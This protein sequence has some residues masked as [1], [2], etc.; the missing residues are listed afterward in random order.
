MF[1]VPVWNEN[2]AIA[3]FKKG[4]KN[5]VRFGTFNLITQEPLNTKINKIRKIEIKRERIHMTS[6]KSSKV[7]NY[8]LV[9][10]SKYYDLVEQ[11]HRIVCFECIPEIQKLFNVGEEDFDSKIAKYNI[12]ILSPYILIDEIGLDK[13][14]PGDMEGRPM[15]SLGKVD[16]DH[17]HLRGIDQLALSQCHDP[18]S[19]S[20]DG[21]RSLKKGMKY[22][23]KIQKQSKKRKKKMKHAHIEIV[24]RQQQSEETALKDLLSDSGYKA[25]PDGPLEVELVSDTVDRIALFWQFLSEYAKSLVSL[26]C[27]STMKI[28]TWPLIPVIVCEEDNP[29]KYFVS[30]K[31]AKFRSLILETSN[32]INKKD[33]S[34]KINNDVVRRWGALYLDTTSSC[35]TVTLKKLFDN[36]DHA[37]AN[38]VRKRYL[39]SITRGLTEK[40]VMKYQQ[41]DGYKNEC[42]E[43]RDEILNWY[44]LLDIAEGDGDNSLALE[45]V[46][47]SIDDQ[48]ASLLKRLP[49]FSTLDCNEMVSLSTYVSAKKGHF[50]N[51]YG[52]PGHHSI[53]RFKHPWSGTSEWDTLFK[54]NLRTATVKLQM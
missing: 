42:L 26:I 30:Y 15:V 28:D 19:S 38:S 17:T 50:P 11:S 10:E 37:T 22:A 8:Y 23:A 14:L 27:D 29:T 25:H 12:K 24:E 39:L 3:S 40:D 2:I 1:S 31:Y 6:Q 13:I 43:L 53:S 52:T 54:A 21:I 41:N 36:N 47:R 48:A 51:C 34:R 32:L 33:L 49:L 44:G 35:V 16:H 18:S 20:S 4:K 5:S 7:A 45:I 9:K 46:K